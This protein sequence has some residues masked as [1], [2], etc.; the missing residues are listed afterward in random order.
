MTPTT[1]TPVPA[2]VLRRTIKA[3]RERVFAAWTQPET[4]A[5]FFSVDDVKAT[6]V[7]L[8]VRTGG[9]YDI[10]VILDD[11]ERML[12]SGVYRDVR[13]PERLVMTWRWQ[14][15]NPADEHESLLS[16]EFN[17]LGDETELVL[18]H[19][20]LATLESRERHEGGWAK[21]IDKLATLL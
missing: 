8:D 14:E 7:H 4:V 15:D 6:D 9:A 3:P 21:I 19:E 16:L 13:V 10:T 17:A 20:Q 12:V 5:K 18:T 11:G 1:T 2:L